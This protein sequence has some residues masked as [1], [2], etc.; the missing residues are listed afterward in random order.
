M[1]WLRG[2][3]RKVRARL[4]R[5]RLGDHAH[6]LAGSPPV[7]AAFEDWDL[8]RGNDDSSGPGPSEPLFAR[9]DLFVVGAPRSQ[10]PLDPRR[11]S[12]LEKELAVRG[13]EAQEWR[14]SRHGHVVQVS[15]AQEALI[16]ENP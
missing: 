1:N 12:A 6:Q 7:S 3:V 4:R 9:D 2:L 10:P 14:E 16:L 11:L 15:D 8:M 13:R 5:R